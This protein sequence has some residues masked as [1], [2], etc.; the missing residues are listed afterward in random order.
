MKR[1]KKV[2]A[3]V[4]AGVLA[5]AM[6]TACGETDSDKLIPADGSYEIVKAINDEAVKN[7]KAEVT[8]SVKYSEVT[9]NL[10]KN[11]LEYYRSP[12]TNSEAYKAGYKA[13]VKDLGNTKIVIGLVDENVAP[14]S[15]T[16][17]LTTANSAFKASTIV[18]DDNYNAANRV[19]VAYYT[20]GA[21]TYRLV[22][23]FCE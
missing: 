4:L 21:T 10:L 22:C 13:A 9:K 17:Y 23:L 6:L 2:L 18:A 19:G 5:L 12:V 8:Y 3:L 11:W 1:F 16:A 20:S 15:S 7:G 14:T